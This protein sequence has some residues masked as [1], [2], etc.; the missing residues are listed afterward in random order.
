[1]QLIQDFEMS[2]TAKFAKYLRWPKN[3]GERS[4]YFKIKK[5][6]H[7]KED[8]KADLCYNMHL[9]ITAWQKETVKIPLEESKGKGGRHQTLTCDQVSM[10]PIVGRCNLLKDILTGGMSFDC[11]LGPQRNSAQMRQ[12]ATEW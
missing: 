5:I 6:I 1:M 4:K 9:C 12:Y 3:F 11:Q 8:V 7:K 2:F 10:I